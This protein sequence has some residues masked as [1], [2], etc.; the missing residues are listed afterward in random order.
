MKTPLD[1]IIRRHAVEIPSN[2]LFI[3][4]YVMPAV[5]VSGKRPCKHNLWCDPHWSYTA[6]SW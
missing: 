1:H 3:K 2:L 5:V 4:V 6:S